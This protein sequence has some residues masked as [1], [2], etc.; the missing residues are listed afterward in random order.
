[1]VVV[2]IYFSVLNRYVRYFAAALAAWPQQRTLAL[3]SAHITG[4]SVLK[5]TAGFVLVVSCRPTGAA[6]AQW[7]AAY[8]V[9][10]AEQVFQSPC[11]LEGDV[12]LEVLAVRLQPVLNVYR[13]QPHLINL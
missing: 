4:R 9:G 3:R 1:M 5:R 7:A 2:S 8:K 11:R 6:A 13:I 10:K 12:K